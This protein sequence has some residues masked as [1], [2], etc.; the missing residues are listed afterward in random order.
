MTPIEV[1]FRLLGKCQDNPA[2][3]EIE[4]TITE[5]LTKKVINRHKVLMRIGNTITVPCFYDE[6]K[7]HQHEK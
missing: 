6:M 4:V 1:V 2:Y 7:A 3:Q 5:V